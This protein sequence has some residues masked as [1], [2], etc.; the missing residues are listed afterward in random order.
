MKLAARICG[1]LS[2]LFLAVCIIACAA[3]SEKKKTGVR[4]KTE[5]TKTAEKTAEEKTEKKR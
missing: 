5:K 3:R 1:A 2:V 4:V